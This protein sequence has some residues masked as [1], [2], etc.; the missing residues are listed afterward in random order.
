MTAF[1]IASAVQPSEQ[2]AAE[3][4]AARDSPSDLQEG[5]PELPPAPPRASSEAE[6]AGPPENRR[7]LRTNA[8]HAPSTSRSP[9]QGH[10]HR[11]RAAPEA[12]IRPAYRDHARRPA[13]DGRVRTRHS[14]G[15]PP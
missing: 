10:S 9:I 14:T 4:A 2:I 15:C 8:G 5:T 13:V 7:A 3:P 6:G 1:A 11:P 12:R